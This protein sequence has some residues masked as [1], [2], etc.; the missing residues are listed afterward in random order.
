MHKP[1]PVEPDEGRVTVS[2]EPWIPQLSPPVSSPIVST[3]I[4][5]DS[6]AVVGSGTVKTMGV[7]AGWPLESASVSADTSNGMITNGT[8][9]ESAPFGPGFFTCMVSVAADCTSA[10]FSPVAH[11]VT[12]AQVVPRVVPLIEM[13]DAALPL[14]ATNPLPCTSSGKLSTALANTLDGKITSIV[15]PLVIATVALA[16][17]LAL[18]WVVAVT[19]TEFGEGAA[20]GAV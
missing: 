17:S 8:G 19:V 16:D 5:A 18:A 14:P 4:A 15:G 6:A 11:V 3:S 12:A 2:G 13:M 1:P 7:A 10:G 20:V 9:F